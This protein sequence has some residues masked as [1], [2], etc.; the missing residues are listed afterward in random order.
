MRIFSKIISFPLFH[1]C[2]VFW[3]G[4]SHKIKHVSCWF[5]PDPMFQG[6]LLNSVFIKTSLFRWGNIS[7]PHESSSTS[8]G[9]TQPSPSAAVSPSAASAAEPRSPWRGRPP[10]G[11]SCQP[12]DRA[13]H[14]LHERSGGPRSIMGLVT[15][16][17]ETTRSCDSFWLRGHASAFT[18]RPLRAALS[19]QTCLDG[20]HVAA[21]LLSVTARV[22]SG[23]RTDRK[24]SG[25]GN[26]AF[27][28]EIW[29]IKG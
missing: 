20:Q 10:A 7:V 16:E 17:S 24:S 29:F 3:V 9:W 13:E 12:A 23:Q 14:L 2:S 25:G 11:P 6:F 4:L 19:C 26:A 21:M 28:S 22:A 27:Q 5:W 1:N 15:G 18:R 8:R